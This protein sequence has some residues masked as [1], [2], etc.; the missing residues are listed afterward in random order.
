[1][2]ADHTSAKTPAAQAFPRYE[3]FPEKHRPAP[4]GESTQAFEERGQLQQSL[5]P[6]LNDRS[7]R[8]RSRFPPAIRARSAH[9]GRSR[10]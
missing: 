6:P 2:L 8:G 1:L 4:T 7:D 10:W 9:C 5:R 3:Q